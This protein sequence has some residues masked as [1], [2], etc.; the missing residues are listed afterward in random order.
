MREYFLKTERLG[1]SKWTANDTELAF[2]LWGDPEVTKLICASGAF[3]D[4]EVRDRLATEIRNG[5]VYGV[6]YWPI[7]E[8]TTGRHAG[9][10]GL[11]PYD[12]PN[13]VYEL[14]F[15]LRRAVWGQGYAVEAALAVIK[16]AFDTL[17]A[18]GLFAGHNPK[19]VASRKILLEKLGF[20]YVG[21]V[22]YPPT[23]LNH[24]SYSYRPDPK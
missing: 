24:P 16:Y 15:H 11:R 18:K 17:D 8:L 19:N 10:C 7:F 2:G 3:T 12:L 5:E 23:G 20:A 1:F 13:G 22:F 4:Q 21:D 6:Q 14:G 9:C